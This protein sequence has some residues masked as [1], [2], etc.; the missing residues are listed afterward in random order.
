[1]ITARD[2]SKHTPRIPQDLMDGLAFWSALT[3]SGRAAATS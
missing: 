2:E 3:Y 1:M